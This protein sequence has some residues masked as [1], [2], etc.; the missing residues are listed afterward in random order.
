MRTYVPFRILA[1]AGMEACWI[2]GYLLLFHHRACEQCLFIPGILCFGPLAF[3]LGRWVRAWRRSG[4]L[5]ETLLWLTWGILAL[6]FTGWTVESVSPFSGHLWLRSLPGRVFSIGSFPSPELLTFSGTALLWGLGQRLSRPFRDDSILHSEFQ[7]GLSM[8]L[9]LLF[10]DGQWGLHIPGLLPLTTAFFLFALTGL[11][12]NLLQGGTDWSSSGR[13]AL[14]SGVVLC[15][16]CLVVA[17]GLLAVT[18]LTPDLMNQVV[19]LLEEIGRWVGAWIAMILSLLAG[20][21]PTPEPQ[22][23]LLPAPAPGIEKDPSI[24]AKLFRI[25]ESLRKIGGFLVAAI[26]LFLFLGAIWTLSVALFQW[27]VRRMARSEE[28]EV[29]PLTGAFKEDLL[30]LMRMLGL[31]MRRLHQGLLR[32]FGRGAPGEAAPASARLV[33]RKLLRWAAH[34]GFPR[35]PFQTPGEYLETLVQRAPGAS[36][37]M[38]FLTAHYVVERYSREEIAPALADEMEAKWKRVKGTKVVS[39][40]ESEV[41]DRGSEIG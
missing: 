31:K 37:E 8:L 9:I 3:L 41:G 39:R 25:P 2:Y 11:A 27:L 26:W 16:V 14:W 33:Y 28:T 29:E 4:A 24:I 38:A 18:L 1:L 34:R 10:L 30:L 6:L 32:L 35:S 12:M 23:L 36:A 5:R 22:G 15:V 21:F 40:R 7:F 19:S 13:R 17:A 20:L